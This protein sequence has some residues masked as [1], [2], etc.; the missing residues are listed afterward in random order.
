MAFGAAPVTYAVG[1]VTVGLD[2]LCLGPNPGA[3]K[4]IK[5]LQQD[6]KIMNLEQFQY[7]HETGEFPNPREVV[8]AVVEEFNKDPSKKRNY[9][10]RDRLFDELESMVNC[11][12]LQ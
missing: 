7:M 1:S 4:M 10:N 2:V 5:A 8:K 9:R 11:S 12:D 3:S 6:V